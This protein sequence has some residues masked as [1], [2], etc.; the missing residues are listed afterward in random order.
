MQDV[1]APA[2]LAR[3]HGWEP[4]YRSRLHYLVTWNTRGRRPVLRPRHAAA[5]ARLLCRICEERG[6]PLL[7]VSVGWDQVHLLFSLRPAQSAASVIRELKGRSSL[8][9]LSELPELR[10]RLGGNLAWDERYAIE[11]VSP[12]RLERMKASLRARHAPPDDSLTRAG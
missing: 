9:L 6:I 1:S 5:L 7:E 3:R 10:L 4:V 11:T 8:D 2:P 12:A